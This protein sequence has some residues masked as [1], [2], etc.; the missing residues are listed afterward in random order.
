LV[1]GIKSNLVDIG[2]GLLIDPLTMQIQTPPPNLF[3][4]IQKLGRAMG[5]NFIKDF[6]DIMWTRFNESLGLDPDAKIGESVKTLGQKM[7]DAIGEALYN[8]VG[9][10]LNQAW[11]DFINSMAI[12]KGQSPGEWGYDPF[13]YYNDLHSKGSGYGDSGITRPSPSGVSSNGS[14]Y[15]INIQTNDQGTI[16]KLREL[17]VAV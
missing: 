2:N 17:G 15:N 13:Q 8:A 12:V 1:G 3:T 16:R 11:N 4:L 7:G 5:G 9:A 14:T 10:K 6:L